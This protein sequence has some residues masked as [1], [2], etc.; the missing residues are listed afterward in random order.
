M[1][2]GIRTLRGAALAALALSTPVAAQQS[3]ALTVDR[4][5]ASPEFRSA[6][7]PSVHWLADGLA[8][9]D[10]RPAEGGGTDIV[11][12]DVATGAV[13]VLASAATLAV[14][15]T[16]LEVDGIELSADERRA[17]ISTGTVPIW[18]RSYRATYYVLDFATKTLTPVSATHQR[19][20]LA[21]L[22][23]DGRTV[24]FV[25]DSNI[26]VTDLA[27]RAERRLTSD[28]S[29]EVIN[30]TTDWVNEEEF[31][32]WD[33]YRWSP[34]SKRIA[35]WRFDQHRVPE[36]TLWNQ[37][38]LYPTPSPI[39]YPKAG[40]PNAV[41]SIGVVDVATGLRR[42][43][44]LGGDSTQYVPRMEWLGPDSLVIQRLPRRQ[45]RVDVLVASATTGR[46]RTLLTDRDSAYVDVMAQP[47]WIEGGRRFLW[48]SDRSGWR[49]LF[50][51]GRDGR[52]VRQVTKNGVDILDVAAVDEARGDV[53]V[54]VAGPGP[55]Q[56]QLFRW[57]L[58]GRRS[59]RVTSAPGTHTVSIGPGARFMVDEYSSASRPPRAAVVDLRTLSQRRVLASNDTLERRVAALGLRP[60]EF[61]KVPMPDGTLLDG[62]RI[63]P[64]TFDSTKRYPV[65]LYVYGGP[66][67]PTVNDAWGGSRY[68]WHQMLAQH[69][70]IVMSV[71]NRGAAWRGREFRKVTQLHLGEHESRDQIDAA[72]WLA[73]QRWVDGA[74]IGI[75]GWSY[76]G[77]MSALSAFTGGS[78]FKAAIAVAPV[79]DW[80]LYDTIYTERYM[81]LPGEN[82]AGY[83]ASA[84]LT[85]VGGLTANFL[86]VHGLTDDNV[87]A[88]NAIQLVD[89]LITARKPFELMLYPTGKHGISA[90]NTPH[91]Y[92][93]LTRF[94]LEKL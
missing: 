63:A 69:G 39:R 29:A 27:T 17:V 74:R 61:L 49:Q 90:S 78:V 91:L 86:L 65:L 72:R 3:A 51:Y 55:T 82:A 9:V 71:D 80:R 5:F 52:L 62:W 84:P 76:G 1:N 26:F 20:M 18:R 68:L 85:H 59:A 25:A 67:A 23:P 75:W 11:R 77:Y 89:R 21:K 37:N 41:V 34:D 83:A 94:V 73:R 12:I 44:D 87:H 43:V 66:A 8:F 13:S 6:T 53:Y 35:F 16:R 14:D 70:Y 57:S 42:W 33:G 30:G 47:V 7:M 64:A 93:L 2:S 50:L 32:F 54:N 88:Q 92:D 45:N 28:A 56:R 46:T 31:E 60:L 48:V 38:T 36:F 4:I 79:T 24:A 19:Q 10:T 58:D 40:E 81:W 22:S 15:G